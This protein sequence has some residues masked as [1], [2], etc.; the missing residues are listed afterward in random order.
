[1][2]GAYMFGFAKSVLPITLYLKSCFTSFSEN[3]PLWLLEPSFVAWINLIYFRKILYLWNKFM[4][5][6]QQMGPDSLKQAWLV[7]FV[8]SLFFLFEFIQLSSFD[9][10]N[11]YIVQFF[12]LN[13][14]QI[15]LLSSAFL[16]GNEFCLLPAG[17][18]L[19]RIGPRRAI[20]WSLG[21]SILGLMIFASSHFFMLAFLG[22]FITGVGNA[23]CFVSLVVLVS[24]WFPASKQAF[25]M[26]ALVNM[27]FIGGMFSHTPL[28]LLLS[29]FGWQTI[30]WA[31]VVFGLLVSILIF[32]TV[33]DYPLHKEAIYLA[34]KA[35]HIPFWQGMRQVLNRQNIFSGLYTSCLNLP[36]IVLC[37]L[38]GIQYLKV[39]HG[40]SL[41]MASNV[42]SMVFLGSMLGCPFFGWLSDKLGNRKPVMWFGAVMT[43]LLCIPLC[44]YGPLSHSLLMLLFFLLGC[45]TSTQ[46]VSYPLIAESNLPLFSG[47]ACSI[48][49]LIIMGGGMIAQ[50]IFGYLLSL[51]HTGRL[52]VGDF[53][54][55]MYLFPMSVLI[56]LFSM[57]LLKETHCRSLVE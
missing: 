37:A 23:F 41:V 27:A 52:D 26:G 51:R 13:S 33:T 45:V 15:S 24:R 39:V 34:A 54:I 18:L 50:M 42:V 53:K 8:A 30:M 5:A 46:V 6:S 3:S 10:L 48:A 14:S 12:H 36:I 28:V 11:P 38:W 20:L 1:M 9:A 43:L 32:R 35:Q 17:L 19:D 7:C 29:L 31:M 25:A 16:W 49:S 40:L 57:M 21:L 55:A 47:R 56:A 2:I 22:R 4:L 44:F